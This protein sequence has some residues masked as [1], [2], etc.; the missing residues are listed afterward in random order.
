MEG[1]YDALGY[2]ATFIGT[3]LEGEILL[4]TS[5]LM[6]KIEQL[7][8]FGC[9]TAAF[10]GAYARDWVIFLIARR[11][12]KKLL[13]NRPKLKSRLDRV[14]S[15]IQQYPNALLIGYRMLYGLSMATVLL[16][17]ISGVSAKKYGLLSAIS[18]L[19]WIA[20]YGGL[21]YFYAETMIKNLEWL[22]D[23]AR[24]LIAALILFG[25]MYWGFVLMKEWRIKS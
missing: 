8:F 3:F 25:L 18:C 23:Y 21:G 2:F 6:W 15:L 10:A 1:S 17:G 11:K 20:V 9:L 19:I 14:N 4:L 5:I 13:D 16:A 22:G 12:G 7:N 24:Y